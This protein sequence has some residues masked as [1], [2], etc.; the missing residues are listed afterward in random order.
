MKSLYFMKIHF[1][2]LRRLQFAAA[3]NMLLGRVSR[4]TSLNNLTKFTIMF[5]IVTRLSNNCYY[6]CVQLTDTQRGFTKPSHSTFPLFGDF[7]HFSGVSI[8]DFRK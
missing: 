2:G 4:F 5:K 7:I 1:L 3:E 6:F 8:A